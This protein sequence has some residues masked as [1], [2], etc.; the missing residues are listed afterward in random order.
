MDI[1]NGYIAVLRRMTPINTEETIVK[2][3]SPEST[4]EEIMKWKEGLTG[5]NCHELGFVIIKA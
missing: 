2:N 3:L 4:I 1:N 5:H